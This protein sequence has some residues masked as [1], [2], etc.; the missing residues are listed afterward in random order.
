MREKKSNYCSRFIYKKKYF[1]NILNSR[2]LYLLKRNILFNKKYKD[3]CYKKE[4]S[5][6]KERNTNYHIEK[7]NHEI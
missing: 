2:I 5:S 6:L 1:K 4:T 3:L 7:A